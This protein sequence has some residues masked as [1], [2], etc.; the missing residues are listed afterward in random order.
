MP[1]KFNTMLKYFNLENLNRLSHLHKLINN[2]ITGT[3]LELSKKLGVSERS[4]Y[5]MIDYLKDFGAKIKYDR[6]LK[7]YHYVNS[8]DLKINFSIKFI[9]DDEIKIINGGYFFSTARLL[10]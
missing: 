1:I 10:Q 5:L 8:F 2:E 6:R 4:T 3:P 7:T 9:N